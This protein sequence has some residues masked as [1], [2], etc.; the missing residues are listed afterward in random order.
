MEAL[1][2]MPVLFSDNGFDVTVCDPPYAGFRWVPDL[3]IYD[4]C[5]GVKAYNTE[6]MY[7]DRYSEDSLEDVTAI[8]K[9][10]FFCYGIFRSAPV[11]LQKLFYDGGKYY[12]IEMYGI[13]TRY[14]DFLKSYSVLTSLPDITD[15]SDGYGDTFLM[16]QNSATHE[17]VILQEPDYDYSETIDNTGL[18]KG[19]RDDGRGNRITFETEDQ[20]KTYHSDM[21]A[22]LRLG[23]WFEEL[24][25]NGVYDNTRI[26]IVSDHGR[27]LGQF[28]YMKLN[29]DVNVEICNSLMMVKDFGSDGFAEDDEFMTLADVPT[30]AVEGII[31]DPVNPF[32]GNRIDDQAKYGR[33]HLIVLKESGIKLDEVLDVS[34]N[35]Y[36]LKKRFYV[37]DNIF[38]PSNWRVVQ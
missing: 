33:E 34:G 23:E 6:G 30:L 5:L 13:R 9:R 12:S 35:E 25:K 18:E 2:V 11:V 38:D 16:L 7:M 21:A 27:N 22:F 3:S 14:G 15:I 19:W 26:I 37:K 32:T 1:K 20:M 8:R 29:D 24:K 10:Q 4:D 28:D 17:P 31:N 36:I